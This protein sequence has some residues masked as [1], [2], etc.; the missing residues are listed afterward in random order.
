[1]WPVPWFSWTRAVQRSFVVWEI[2]T[3]SFIQMYCPS[4][5]KERAYIDKYCSRNRTGKPYAAHVARLDYLLIYL[6]TQVQLTLT[7]IIKIVAIR[8]RILR[9]KCTKFDFGWGSAPD[10]AGGAYSALPD[11]L[12]GFGGPTSKERGREGGEGR[13]GEGRRGKGGRGGEE[14]GREEREGEG[15]GRKGPWAPPLFEGSLRLW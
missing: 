8:W 9:L 14:R 13:K 4:C 1:V 11:P 7:K 12:A 3:V 15:R 2:E 10:P 6:P 5:G